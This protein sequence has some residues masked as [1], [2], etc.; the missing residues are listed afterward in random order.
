MSPIRRR[1]LSAVGASIVVGTAGC[2]EQLSSDPLELATPEATPD[3]DWTA[4]D[5]E[6]A[7]GEPS[8]DDVEPTTVVSGLEIPWDLTFAGADAFVTERDGGLLR[9]DAADLETRSDLVPADAD[10]VLERTDLPDRAAPGEGGTLGVAGHPD[11]PDEPLLFVYYTVDDGVGNRVVRYDLE[12]SDLEPILDE[13]PG[14]TTHNGGRITVG[15]DDYLWVLTGDA[16]E[17]ALTQ[18][19][20]SLAGA[21]LRVDTDGEPAPDNPDW[22]ADGDPRTYTL[23]HRNPQG[24]DF[25]PQG[26]PLIAEH[27]PVARDEVAMLRPGSN[28]GWDVTRGG[29][30]DPDYEN[31]EEHTAVTPPL[32]NTG[33][34]TT[35]APSGLTFYDEDAIEPWENRV[36]VCG[37]VSETLYGVTLR[38]GNENEGGENEDDADAVYDGPWLDDRFTATVSTLFEGTYGRLRHAAPGPDGSLY[39]LTSNRDGRASGAFP[40][41][42]DDR[43]VRIEV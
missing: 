30:N 22:G 7:D 8:E 26:A 33:P 19:P 31:Y 36:F 27:G 10:V 25:T 3:D 12:S 20:S 5:W 42:R 28:Y 39:V 16:E 11:Y 43:I 17:P 14:A 41:E 40:L 4:P 23:G 18:D 21:V 1:L 29:P 38:T 2:L 15:P 24:I 34:E 37:L 13:I 6:P 32:V 9:F 35:W